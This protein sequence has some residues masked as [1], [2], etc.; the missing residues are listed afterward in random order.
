MSKPKIKIIFVEDAVV[1]CPNKGKTFEAKE[2]D[3]R[4]LEAP[5]ARYWISTR[6][7]QS[8]EAPTSEAPTESSTKTTKKA[9]RKKKD[10]S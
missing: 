1:M 5:S 9:T 10:V 7:A 4:E 6:K 8:Y 2:G 3:V